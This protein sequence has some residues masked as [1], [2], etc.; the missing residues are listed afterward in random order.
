MAFQTSPLT[1]LGHFNLCGASKEFVEFIKEISGPFHGSVIF[2]VKVR[3]HEGSCCRDMVQRHV[4]ATKRCAVHT[5]V[6]CFSVVWRGHVSATKSQHGRTHENV[7]GTCFRDMLHRHV[8]SC[9]QILYNSAT[10]IWGLFCP[11]EVSQEV[12][13]FKI[14]GTGHRAKI[15]PKLVLHTYKSISS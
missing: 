10:P 7:A 3:R 6:T 13:L 12:Q 4:R 5:D 9:E 2:V 14:Q 8:P 15:T 11:S 1:Y